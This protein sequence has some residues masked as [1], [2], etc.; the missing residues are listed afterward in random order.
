MKTKDEFINSRASERKDLSAQVNLMEAKAGRAMIDDKLQYDDES[1]V[2]HA[3]LHENVE[4]LEE[5]GGDTLE[6]DNESAYE[7]F[8]FPGI[9]F[10]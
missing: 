9:I 10:Y 7:D 3:N 5:S 4:K 8:D 1:D 2:L 6:T